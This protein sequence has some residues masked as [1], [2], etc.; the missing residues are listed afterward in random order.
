M[1]LPPYKIVRFS[2]CVGKCCVKSFLFIKASL[3]TLYLLS[4][5]GIYI[6]DQPPCSTRLD[7]GLN[8]ISLTPTPS[9]LLGCSC[10]LLTGSSQ[11]CTPS[12]L[13][14]IL[15]IRYGS[16]PSIS[17]SLWNFFFTHLII[18]QAKIVRPVTSKSN[19]T[20][21]L[22]KPHGLRYLFLTKSIV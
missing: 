22:S 2:H 4:L 16:G 3:C 17:V 10:C 13:Y 8:I 5:N 18:S 6:G 15:D 14:N 12:S 21:L 19:I 20:P 7:P 1:K 9:C 11:N